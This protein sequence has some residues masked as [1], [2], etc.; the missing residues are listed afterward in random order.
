MQEM[1]ERRERAEDQPGVYEEQV[2]TESILICTKCGGPRTPR[3]LGPNG[4]CGSCIDKDDVPRNIEPPTVCPSCGESETGRATYQKV[5]T[6]SDLVSDFSEQGHIKE[7]KF[8][9]RR[10]HV[11]IEP[12][13]FYGLDHKPLEFEVNELGWLVTIPKL[14]ATGDTVFYAFHCPCQASNKPETTPNALVGAVEGIE[15]DGPHSDGTIP[16]KD[17][18]PQTDCSRCGLVCGCTFCSSCEKRT[19]EC[20]CNPNPEPVALV[21][22]RVKTFDMEWVGAQYAQYQ[23]MVEAKE[24]NDGDWCRSDD[25]AKLETEIAELRALVREAMEEISE[26]SRWY[27]RAKKALEG[28]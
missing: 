23:E 19:D 12:T 20:S 3:H 1:F 14:S 8:L 2:M 16:W 5:T 7:F 22:A 13:A 21:Q 10:E 9:I 27:E 15:Y 25:V 4:V 26:H 17:G 18:V 11:S 24:F 6:N 28:S